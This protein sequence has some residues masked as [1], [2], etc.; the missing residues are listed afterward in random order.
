MPAATDNQ[1]A[2]RDDAIA[3]RNYLIF[4]AAGTAA[5]IALV[6]GAIALL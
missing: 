4:C 1:D 2:R 5:M 6:G 3:R